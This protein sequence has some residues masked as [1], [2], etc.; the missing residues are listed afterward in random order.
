MAPM[1]TPKEI[2]KVLNGALAAAP[3][4]RI[5][6]AQLA[7]L[8]PAMETDEDREKLFERLERELDGHERLFRN[9]ADGSYSLRERFFNGQC[10]VVTPD[11]YE[12]EHNIL[13]PGHRFAAFC[14]ED[15]FP[16]EVTLL[17]SNAGRELETRRFDAGLPEVIHYHLLLGSEQLFDF[18]IAES[19]ANAALLNHDA[20]PVKTV[21]LN[22]FDLTE[23]YRQNQFSSGDALLL[24]VEN[25]ED[26]VFR[27]QYLNSLE[28]RDQAVKQWIKAFDTALEQV[29]DRFDDYLEITDQLRWGY[30]L[31]GA[32]LFGNTSASL[33]EYIQNTSAIAVNVENSGH[34]V[35]VKKDFARDD[36]LLVPDEVSISRGNVSNFNDILRDIGTTL[37]AAEVDS[38]MLDQCFRRD[39]A[40]DSFFSRCFGDRKLAFADEAQEVSFLNQLEERWENLSETYN[41]YEDEAKAE[42]RSQILDLVDERTAFF[43]TLQALE[44]ETD[45]L[46]ESEMRRLAESAL[47]LS[48]LLDLLNAPGNTLQESEAE[49]LAELIDEMAVTQEEAIAALNAFME[50]GSE[51]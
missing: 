47:Y 19:P 21:E 16:S 12:I 34:S 2:E 33:D 17:S 38:Y 36:E 43:D 9:F 26:G 23:F 51:G 8:L 49:E 32:A 4:G 29:I 20:A 14:A 46:P 5:T 44:V 45:H 22:V 40:F 24:T 7:G 42:L 11:D 37:T 30:F 50:K 1:I 35:L 31:G 6:V 15:V 13:V 27:F 39:L 41:R 28:R 25:W 3:G 48:N 18:F 10:F